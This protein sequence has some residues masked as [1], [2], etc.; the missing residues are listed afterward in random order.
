MVWTRTRRPA[1]GYL[2]HHKTLRILAA[3]HRVC[4]LC[5]HGDAEQVDHLVPWS[6]WTDPEISVHHHSN[7]APLHGEPCPTCGQQCHLGKTLA[8]AARGRARGNDQRKR[9]SKRPIEPHP[10]LLR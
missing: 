5:G 6:E 8:E 1:S 3:H 4:Y 2:P 10:G 9:A 7:L